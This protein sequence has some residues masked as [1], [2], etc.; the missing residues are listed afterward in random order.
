VGRD[1]RQ[2]NVRIDHVGVHARRLDDLHRGDDALE[3]QCGPQEQHVDTLERTQPLLL[4]VQARGDEAGTGRQ[5][6]AEAALRHHLAHARAPDRGHDR[7]AQLRLLGL[8]VR[9]S[10]AVGQHRVH[11]VGAAEGL[12]QERRVA[13]VA[14]AR[15]STR[16][17]QL[18]QHPRLAADGADGFA[19][20]QQPMH[21]LAS[22]V[23]GR[24]HYSDHLAILD[25]AMSIPA[26]IRAEGNEPGGRCVRDR[27]STSRSRM[28]ITNRYTN[29]Q[30]SLN[31][32]RDP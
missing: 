29:R 1:H 24:A 16:G 5:L 18:G 3:E 21:D 8:E 22:D 2:R 30:A 9:R 26:P 4:R 17:G 25:R 10:R 12:G 7:R 27:V 19:R 32:D 6:G 31:S 13:G 11:G 28:P 14:C 20:L 23:A 15:L